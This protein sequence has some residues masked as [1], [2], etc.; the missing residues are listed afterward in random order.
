MPHKKQFHFSP[1]EIDAKRHQIDAWMARNGHD[2]RSLA[3]L[4]GI[5]PETVQVNMGREHLKTRRP[6]SDKFLLVVQRVTNLPLVPSEAEA[7]VAP[8]A[9]FESTAP[10][11]IVTFLGSANLASASQLARL[12]RRSQSQLNRIVAPMVQDG[13]LQR[14]RTLA[15]D[16]QPPRTQE[17]VYGLGPAGRVLAKGML[18]RAVPALFTKQGQLRSSMFLRHDLQVTEFALRLNLELPDQLVAW[19]C[20][21]LTHD[22]IPGRSGRT[23]VEPDLMFE[24]SLAA[25]KSPS[26]VADTA[27]RRGRD[28]ANGGVTRG[29]ACGWV[30]VEQ[31]TLGRVAVQEKV[32]AADRYYLNGGFQKRWQAERLTLLWIGTNDEHAH[33]LRDWIGVLRPRLQHAVSSWDWLRQSGCTAPI[34]LTL[35]SGEE[36][37][38]L[39][40]AAREDQ[41]DL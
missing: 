37:R 8:S 40:L 2:D 22:K 34:W 12:T 9:I 15:P 25:A 24:L 16:S 13:Q 26:P 19:E 39:R 33:R 18:G 20:D 38:A 35:N 17:F 4:L 11:L 36:R 31:D 6:P 21:P 41:T 14:A 30:E 32:R 23:V 3:R 10:E 1:I 28:W 29:A 27:S 7:A 5:K